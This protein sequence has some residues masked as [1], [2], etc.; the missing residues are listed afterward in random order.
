MKRRRP[1]AKRGRVTK[2]PK[3]QHLTD[4]ELTL[5]YLNADENLALE[6]LDGKFEKDDRGKM[7]HRFHEPGSE[8]ETRS[9]AVLIKLL[10]ESRELSPRIRFRLADLL[11][12]DSQYEERTFTIANRRSGP[13]PHHALMK[14]I[15]WFIALK[16]A[17]GEK[18]EATKEAVKELYG[19]S[20]STVDRAWADHK[21]SELIKSICGKRV[22]Q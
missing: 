15:A 22:E 16:I 8:E 14:Q 10:R 19:V 20:M 4:E 2:H 6:Y 12:P 17:H 3:H 18:M 11:D 5:A 21:N 13:Q 1:I 9:R 7:I